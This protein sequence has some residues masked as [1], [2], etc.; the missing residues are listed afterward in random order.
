[1]LFQNC[2]YQALSIQSRFNIADRIKGLKV[3][4]KGL[5]NTDN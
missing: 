4:G 5:K 3:L 1:M 2:L